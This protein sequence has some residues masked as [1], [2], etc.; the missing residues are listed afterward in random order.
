[1]P[2]L[3]RTDILGAKDLGLTPVEVPEWGGT[4]YVRSMTARER[5]TW[6]G[7]IRE[8]FVGA[9]RSFRRRRRK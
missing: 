3:S 2:S 4:V 8:Q 6:E 7:M 5:I 9:R 1:M